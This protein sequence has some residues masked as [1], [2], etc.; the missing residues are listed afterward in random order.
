MFLYFNFLVLVCFDPYIESLLPLVVFEVLWT[1]IEKM[2][3]R[4]DMSDSQDTTSS[5]S[6][7]R[8]DRDDVEVVDQMYDVAD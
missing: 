7:F 5:R 2:S 8:D 1:V 4:S 3:S 6:A